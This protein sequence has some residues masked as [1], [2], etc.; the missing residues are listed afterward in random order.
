M[1]D[2]RCQL[3]GEST[4]VAARRSFL[5]TIDT[6]G[7]NLWSRPTTITTR[8]AA[9]LPRF[10]ALCER[11]GLKP[12]WLTNYEMATCPVFQE[13][14][15][16]VAARGTAEIGMHLHAWNSPPIAPLTDNDY[17]H[18]PFLIEY[19]KHVQHQKVSLMTNLLRET[20]PSAVISHRAGR[21]ALDASYAQILIDH[22]YLV[23]CSVTPHV[24]W[25]D[26]KG[27]PCGTGGSDYR[28]APDAAYFMSAT[29][30]TTPGASTLLE[31]PMTTRSVSQ[32]TGIRLAASMIRKA[33]LR[34]LRRIG[35]RFLPEV[36]WLRPNG[37]N[38]RE[39]LG[40]LDEVA[41][42]ESGYAEFM[43]H[44]SELMPGGSP[45]F[46]NERAV[47]RLYEDLE[48]VFEATT[49]RFHGATLQEFHAAFVSSS[50]AM[51]ASHGADTSEPC[52]GSQEN[53]LDTL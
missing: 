20:F 5:I 49:D 26:T 38:R 37:R 33:P 34:I 25:R 28:R 8:N 50:R 53:L 4:S 3:A 27:K 12:T 14:G 43:L 22:G 6:E 51:P 39:M 31:V 41:G 40:L 29:D 24:S 2:T 9:Y 21:W 52:C 30:V 18:Q 47:E 19:P 46:P 23:D 16:H 32:S 45:R 36:R 48:A 42:R 11:Y 1:N 10:Q 17:A 7:D 13:F 15:R 35:H 44:S